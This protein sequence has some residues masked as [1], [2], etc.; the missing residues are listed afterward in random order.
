VLL[1]QKAHKELRV[2]LPQQLVLKVPIILDL[3][4]LKVPKVQLA[5]REL[6]VPLVL[7]MHDS[8]KMLLR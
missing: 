8:K 5:L 1:A 4:V 6:Q 7:L 2:L 3:L